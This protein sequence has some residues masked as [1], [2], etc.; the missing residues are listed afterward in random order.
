MP[1]ALLEAMACG[2]PVVSTRTDGVRQVLGPLSDQ[3]T[4][5]DSS[6]QAIAEK[7]VTISKDTALSRHLGSRNQ[8]RVRHEFSLENMVAQYERLFEALAATAKD[9]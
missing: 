7:V 9:E 5:P 2:L 8:L 1:N 3:Q 6:P 4:V